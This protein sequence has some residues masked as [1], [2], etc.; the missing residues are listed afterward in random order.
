MTEPQAAPSQTQSPY[1]AL[2]GAG[3]EQAREALSGIAKMFPT[4]AAS[5]VFVEEAQKLEYFKNA[6]I[7]SLLSGPGGAIPSGI[8][9]ATM[10]Y[11]SAVRLQ[12]Q[13]LA[14]A[15][16]PAARAGKH[17]PVMGRGR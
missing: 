3:V 15:G 10:A 5:P 17:A 7:G 9:D 12:L 11:T 14:Q 13:L 4:A 16:T 2:N 1:A 6:M 8:I